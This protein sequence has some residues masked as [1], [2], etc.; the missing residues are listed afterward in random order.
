MLAHVRLT[1]SALPS[2]ER[3]QE[4]KTS[5]RTAGLY[6]WALNTQPKKKTGSNIKR[7][8]NIQNHENNY[9]Y[10]SVSL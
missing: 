3:D 7:Q 10:L 9:S 5:P 1:W 2:D 4:E 6:V 8:R